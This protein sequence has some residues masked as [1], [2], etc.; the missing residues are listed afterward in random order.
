MD[1]GDIVSRLDDAMA[2]GYAQGVEA[3]EARAIKRIDKLEA[4]VAAFK[5]QN[6]RIA[7]MRI[8]DCQRAEKAEDML[9][10]YAAE[11]EHAKDQI[12]ELRLQRND[13]SVL[14]GRAANM[15][16]NV[17]KAQTILNGDGTHLGLHRD[18]LK[19]IVRMAQSCW[20]SYQKL[21]DIEDAGKLGYPYFRE[22]ADTLARMDSPVHNRNAMALIDGL[23]LAR[24]E[25][26]EQMEQRASETRINDNLAK[27]CVKA[28]GLVNA[29]RKSLEI[30]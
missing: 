13:V 8:D 10:F 16:E 25:V 27:R 7:G 30:D 5:D 15:F 17:G 14:D 24:E 18:V 12:K 3:T 20:A 6:K 22:W 9:E 4:D 1:E 21:K 28:E 2:A 11:L 19:D 26:E 29:L 23:R